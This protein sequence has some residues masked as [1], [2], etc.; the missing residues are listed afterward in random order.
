MKL[1]SLMSGNISYELEF[2]L[3]FYVQLLFIQIS[4]NT[5]IHGDFSLLCMKHLSGNVN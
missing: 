1:Y 4:K 2:S 3:A 5:N